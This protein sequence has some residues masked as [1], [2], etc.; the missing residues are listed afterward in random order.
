[1]RA[2]HSLTGAKAIMYNQSQC[3]HPRLQWSNNGSA[4]VSV[5]MAN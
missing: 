4:S 3:T 2:I 5:L 1:M